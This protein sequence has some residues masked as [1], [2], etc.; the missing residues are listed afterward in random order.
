VSFQNVYVYEDKEGDWKTETQQRLLRIE[1]LSDEPLTIVPSSNLPIE[2][3]WTGMLSV[4]IS[5]SP[6]NK[7]N[8]VF[9]APEDWL[10]EVSDPLLALAVLKS[11]NEVASDMPSGPQIEIPP[12]QNAVLVV[13][14]PSITLDVAK[15]HENQLH[16]GQFAQQGSERKKK[17]HTFLVKLINNNKKLKKDGALVLTSI[18][19][20]WGSRARISKVFSIHTQYW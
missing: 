2:L 16:S 9:A 12:K 7:I 20:S 1:N 17:K 19:K 15:E 10:C 11:M 3:Y 5:I 14:T 8:N 6:K 13:S 18:R 4:L